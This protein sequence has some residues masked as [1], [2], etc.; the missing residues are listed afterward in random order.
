MC[1]GATYSNLAAA[2][3]GSAIPATKPQMLLLDC[4][5]QSSSKSDEAQL[6]A[7]LVERAKKLG[8][9]LPQDAAALARSFLETSLP[10]LRQF[11]CVA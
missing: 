10:R 8:I 3:F 11:G 2:Q 1:Q 5:L 4:W 9:E 6:A 7:G